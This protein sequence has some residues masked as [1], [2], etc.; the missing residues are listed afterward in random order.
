VA[1]VC[2]ETLPQH[3]A[4]GA[5]NGP[6]KPKHRRGVSIVVNKSLL[7]AKK[8]RHRTVVEGRVTLLEIPW[9]EG[10]VLRIMNVYAPAQNSEK[11]EFWKRLLEVVEGEDDLKP[12]IVLGDFNLV[13]NPE[14][15]RLINRG[16]ADPPWRGTNCRTSWWR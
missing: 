4:H 13:E 15:D 14:I 3:P 9:S 6:R 11:A 8:V 5:L 10:D 2:G 7:D 12:D 1:E 16:G